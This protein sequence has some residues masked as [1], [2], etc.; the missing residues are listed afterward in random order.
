M[1]APMI[2]PAAVA[3]SWYP[4]TRGALEHEVDR[5]L[6]A[7]KVSPLRDVVAL[8]SPHAGMMFS[9]GVAA[10]AYRAVAEQD[11]DTVVLV[12]PSHYV[13]FEGVAIYPEGGF[14][15]PLGVAEIDRDVA[16]RL[17]AA[18]PLIRPHAPAHAREHSLEMQLPFVQRVLSARIVPM[19][20]GSQTRATITALAKALAQALEGR[21]ALIV[22]S[23]DLSHFF[24]AKRAEKLDGLVRQFVEAF[25]AEG[26]LNEFES[27]PEHERGRY[28]A[29]GGG[30][31]IAAMLAART[32]G[33]SAG[34]V[35]RYAH[36]GDVSGDRS[37]VVGYLAAAFTRAAVH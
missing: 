26:L 7:A 23:T 14:E 27:Y 21:R 12:G 35:L 1:R 20:I 11:V 25:D 5:L 37:A 28:V 24:D 36:S 9:G 3:G 13:G 15:T 16:A 34:R 22:A 33:A 8:I 30:A 4:G 19:A 18:S 6:A 31:A 10:H 29:C 32:L 17:M 2:R